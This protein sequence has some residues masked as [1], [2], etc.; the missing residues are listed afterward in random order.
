MQVNK[1]GKNEI[2][3]NIKEIYTTRFSI[4]I[5]IKEYML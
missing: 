2:T 1:D 3:N 4:W 5:I